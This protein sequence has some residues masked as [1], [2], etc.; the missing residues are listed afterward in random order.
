MKRR[1]VF[2][3]VLGTA[4][5][6]V[7]SGASAQSS[8]ASASAVAELM[9]AKGLSPTM[10]EAARIAA[11]LQSTRRRRSVDPRVEPAIRPDPELD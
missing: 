2:H 6:S 11:F 9:M 3:A 5:A 1:D 10:G 4:G 7:A 8:S